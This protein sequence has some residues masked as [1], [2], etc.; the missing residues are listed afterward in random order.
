M[1][2]GTGFDLVAITVERHP[3]ASE[4]EQWPVIAER[5][6]HHILFLGLRVRLRRV[7]GEA[8]GRDQAAVLGLSQPRQCD[9]D[10]FLMFVTGAPPVR[11]GGGI[12]QRI[13]VISVPASVL[14]TTGA[15]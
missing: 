3:H 1:R 13:R 12:P 15:G 7:L 11:G 2:P 6:P 14:R 10:V 5:K 4:G 8:V 9:D